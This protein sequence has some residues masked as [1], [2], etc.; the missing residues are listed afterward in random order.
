[1]GDA[2]KI[3]R[4][5]REHGDAL[6]M[7]GDDTNVSIGPSGSI[8]PLAIGGE[9]THVKLAA[10]RYTEDDQRLVTE[11]EDIEFSLE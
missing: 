6:F 2:A 7:N 3:E 1:M 9:V 8:S 5:M 4:L 11:D 10:R